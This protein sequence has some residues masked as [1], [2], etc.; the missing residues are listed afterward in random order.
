MALQRSSRL[1]DVQ[2]EAQIVDAP[3]FVE[4]HWASRGI[5]RAEGYA[6][7]RERKRDDE[8]TAR[9]RQ[10]DSRITRLVQLGGRRLKVGRRGRSSVGR[11][12]M[13]LAG[14]KTRVLRGRRQS[15]A[16]SRESALARSS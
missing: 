4:E 9:L 6:K 16:V 1:D 14:S 7:E 12:G 10:I 15:R 8:E 3:E 11:T 2:A 5:E 13:L